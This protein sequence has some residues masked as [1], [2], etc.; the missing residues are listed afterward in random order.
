M[1][2]SVGEL[3]YKTKDKSRS[4]A[5]TQSEA[6]GNKTKVKKCQGAGCKIQRVFNI[7]YAPCNK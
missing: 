6:W 2:V 3:K 7:D 5:K 1:F 4:E